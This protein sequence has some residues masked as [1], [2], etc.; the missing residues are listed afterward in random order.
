L[1]RVLQQQHRIAY[2]FIS[3]DL[4]VVK[5]LADHVV[6]MKSGVAVESGPAAEL[7][8]APQHPYTQALFTAAFELEAAPR[9]EA[10]KSPAVVAAHPPLQTPAGIGRN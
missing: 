9:P 7:F 10:S 2:L 1:L 5:A 4:A 6:V 3:H 8:A